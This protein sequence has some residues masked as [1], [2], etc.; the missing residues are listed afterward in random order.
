[1]PASKFYNEGDADEILRIAVS[2]SVAT[3]AMTRERLLATASELGIS[4]EAVERAEKQLEAQRAETERKAT[5][6][7]ELAEFKAYNRG[8]VLSSL[9]NWAGT[10]VLLLGINLLTSHGIDWALWPVGIWGLYEI[11]QVIENLFSHPSTGQAFERWKR[12]EERR[13]AR[14]SLRSGEIE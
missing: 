1:M 3:G 13:A 2:D 4:E 8:K 7:K 11:G 10:S 5:E 6:A 9:G 14:R 12:R